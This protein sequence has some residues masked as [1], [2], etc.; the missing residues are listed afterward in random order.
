[1]ESPTRLWERP[2][3]FSLTHNTRTQFFLIHGKAGV[4]VPSRQS[5][6]ISPASQSPTQVFK[7]HQL[8]PGANI[9]SQK[10][11]WSNTQASIIP[12]SSFFL[13]LPHLRKTNAVGLLGFSESERSGDAVGL[14]MKLFQVWASVCLHLYAWHFFWIL[15]HWCANEIRNTCRCCHDDQ[16][17][18]IC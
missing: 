4:T 15:F 2:A 17:V 16:M 3:L 5:P 7:D 8:L 13:Y 9:T 14:W 18:Y 6:S 1:M 12:C 10:G 11:R